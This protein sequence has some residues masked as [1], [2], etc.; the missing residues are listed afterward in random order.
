MG[1]FSSKSKPNC[2][3]CG[4]KTGFGSI[5]C[6]D[7]IVCGDC[8]LNQHKQSKTLTSKLT[9]QEIKNYINSGVEYADRLNKFNVTRKIGKFFEVDERRREWLVPDGVLGTKKKPKI[10]K[11]EDISSFELIEDNDTITKGGL[12]RAVVGG[13][14]LGGA[15]AIV[16]GITGKRKGKKVINKLFIKI[17][18]NDF[19][20]PVVMIKLINV[21]TKSDSLAYNGAF[22]TAQEILSLLELIVKQCESKFDNDKKNEADI[23][24]D[25]IFC[26]K[27]GNKMQSDSVFCSKCGEKL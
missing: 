1:I 27:C 3:I 18:V 2:D 12:G 11:F 8:N 5:R 20:N 21:P 7:G 23:N 9:L 25:F 13:A 4:K 17:T 14:L 26:R 24:S 19:N 16:G 22:K 10:Y 15:G 6:L